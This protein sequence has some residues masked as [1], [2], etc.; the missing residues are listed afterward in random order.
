[1]LKQKR[2]NIEI[3]QELVANKDIQ[4]LAEFASGKSFDWV[5]IIVLT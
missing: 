4:H 5:A 3:L 2:S 1:M